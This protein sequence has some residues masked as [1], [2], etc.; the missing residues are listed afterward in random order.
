MYLL[1]FW[2]FHIFFYVNVRKV[3]LSVIN[4][5]YSIYGK[6]TCDS[7]THI[8]SILTI[9]LLYL[10]VLWNY[11]ALNIFVKCLVI[12]INSFQT[13]LVV[14]KIT[15]VQAIHYATHQLRRF[16]GFTKTNSNHFTN[17]TPVWGESKAETLSD[18]EDQKTTRFYINWP[19]SLKNL[20]WLIS[21]QIFSR[22][23]IYK[24]FEIFYSMFK[25]IMIK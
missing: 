3:F 21:L 10:K 1:L 4:Y 20:Y 17:L 18:S 12:F 15:L 13:S 2:N 19:I 22:L 25:M 11:L 23:S 24:Y 5:Q 7:K 16:L 6:L 9:H 14:L 8:I